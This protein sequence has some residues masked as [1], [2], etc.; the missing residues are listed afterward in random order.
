MTVTDDRATSDAATGEQTH[1]RTCPLCEASCGLEL[2]V[3]DGAVVRVR[4]DRNNPFSRG[5]IC[6]KGS[7]LQRIHEDPDR[8]RAPL[9][10]RGD[11]PATATWEEVSWQEAYEEI[12]RHLLPIMEEHGRDAV[13]VYLGNPNA[14]TL[15][16]VLYVR[17]F[18]RALGTRNLFSASTVDQMPKHVSS[19]HMFGNALAI[20]VPDLDRTDYLLMLGANPWESN[21]SLCTA[22]DFPGRLKAIQA[23]GGRFVVV[24]PRRTK[25]AEE[26]DEHI[27]I[28][29]G[30][31]AQFLLALVNV[32]FEDDLVSLGRL[33][34]FTSGVDEVRL[35]A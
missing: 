26:A 30:A 18:I 9:I 28:R 23:R 3:R 16:G 35:A 20:P 32:L 31:D 8:L 33:E 27:A 13:G 15:A 2:T 25:T 1:Y 19:G 17:P 22:P 7:A 21:G 34:A 10:R 11:D 12:E 14:H 5:F 24:D 6:P 4:G 29:P